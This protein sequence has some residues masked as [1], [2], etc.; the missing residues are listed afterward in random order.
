VWHVALCFRK[1]WDIYCSGESALC[2]RGEHIPDYVGEGYDDRLHPVI[3]SFRPVVSSDQP[4]LQWKARPVS[5]PTLPNNHT[6][7]CQN[8]I[9]T[10]TQLQVNL[11]PPIATHFWSSLHRR[12]VYCSPSPRLIWTRIIASLVQGLLEKKGKSKPT[13]LLYLFR[14]HQS[15]ALVSSYLCNSYSEVCNKFFVFLRRCYARGMVFSLLEFGLWSF[16]LCFF[17]W[18]SKQSDTCL[19]WGYLLGLNFYGR[20]H[21]PLSP[22]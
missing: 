2:K 15:I 13:R 17:W 7:L 21:F 6:G 19:L 1:G 4:I 10:R 22:R 9:T 8:S 3:R 20:Q 11:P 18:G 16:F 14:R 12:L 5:T